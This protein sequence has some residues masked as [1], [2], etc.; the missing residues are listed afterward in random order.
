ML[1]NQ[2]VS[3]TQWS[4]RKQLRIGNRLLKRVKFGPEPD[5][6]RITAGME[7]K[8]IVKTSVKG[9][10]NIE[11]KERAVWLPML[12]SEQIIAGLPKQIMYAA[13]DD[14][15]DGDGKNDIGLGW[16]L[17]GKRHKGQLLAKVS[18]NAE[19]VRKVIAVRGSVWK[20]TQKLDQNPLAS[21]PTMSNAA[22]DA[23]NGS[24]YFKNNTFSIERTNIHY[25]L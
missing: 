7:R 22:F 8:K 2:S 13:T 19:G 6:V 24:Y 12:G 11:C 21:T 23:K 14:K 3:E 15:E 18:H 20:D 1:T 17:S 16:K 9:D 5:L 4:E 10:W 25:E